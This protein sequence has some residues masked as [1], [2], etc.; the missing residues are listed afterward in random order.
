MYISLPLLHDFSLSKLECGPKKSTPGKFVYIRLFQR[1]EINAKKFGKKTLVHFKSVL[2]AAAAA[3]AVVEAKTPLLGERRSTEWG[4]HGFKPRPDQQPGSLKNWRDHVEDLISV[5][6]FTSL[7]SDVKPL[8][9]SPS[10]F[11]INWKGT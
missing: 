2:F 5:K 10:S 9:L 11:L 7:G 8:A 4:G 3:V 6:M 1:I